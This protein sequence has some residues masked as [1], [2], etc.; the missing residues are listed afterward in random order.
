[1]TETA[2]FSIL[3]NGNA[4]PDT[5]Q[6][7]SID[8]DHAVNTIS[9]A[10]I[11]FLDGNAQTGVFDLTDS[12][13]LIPGNDIAIQCGYDNSAETVFKGLIVK[14]HIETDGQAGTILKITCR[15]DA[16]KMMVGLKDKLFLNLSDQ[17]V[18]R[19]IIDS[20]GLANSVK[21]MPVKHEILVQRST[22]WDFI[23]SRASVCGS[24]VVLTEADITIDKPDFAA[25]AVLS[26]T[27]S[28]NIISFSAMSGTPVQNGITTAAANTLTGEVKIQGNAMPKPGAMI[29]LQGI[30][31][32]FSGNAFIN[33]VNHNFVNGIWITIIKLGLDDTMTPNTGQSHTPTGLQLA[34]VIKLAGDPAGQFRIFVRPAQYSDGGIWARMTNFYASNGFG[35]SFL[36]EIGDEVIIGDLAED[37]GS[38]LVLG[39]LYSHLRPN[40]QKATDNN[41]IKSIVTRGGLSISFDDGKKII[42]IETPGG[43]TFVLDDDNT[44]VK[45]SD[46]QGN[47]LLMDATGISLKSG[48][49]ITIEAKGNIRMNATGQINLAAIQDVD[50]SGLNINNEAQVGFCAKGNATAEISAAGQTTVKGGIVMI[51]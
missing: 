49:D 1:M 29:N 14:Q 2:I 46:Q 15:H 25:P 21:N 30:G 26:A 34:A 18:L 24:L 40:R 7:I 50:V 39:S 22:D 17:D 12:D 5:F 35:A 13:W 10:T 37:A 48:K 33:G 44:A 47:Q 3:I 9:S 38:P 23:L 31:K 27:Y 4:I 19:D 51:N 32:R 20:Y 8:I 45:M 16:V 11:S 43:N 28:D 6:V 41:D 42:K 36:P